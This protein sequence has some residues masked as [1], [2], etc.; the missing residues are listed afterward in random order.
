MQRK[1]EIKPAKAAYI[2]GV[3]EHD[4]VDCIVSLTYPC[5][6]SGLGLGGPIALWRE[7]VGSDSRS[8]WRNIPVRAITG[9]LLMFTSSQR[10]PNLSTINSKVHRVIHSR[11]FSC[12]TY[13]SSKSFRAPGPK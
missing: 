9:L 10:Y 7:D 3:V 8:R 6:V 2:E 1:R 11:A 4:I 5:I 13:W 12:E